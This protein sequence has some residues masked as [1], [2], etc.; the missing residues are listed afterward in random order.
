MRYLPKWGDTC[1]LPTTDSTKEINQNCFQYEKGVCVHACMCLMGQVDI[2]IFFFFTFNY[3]F[4]CPIVWICNTIITYTSIVF[5]SLKSCFI[6]I[7]SPLK[8]YTAKAIILS[9][10]PS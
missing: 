9:L 5:Y 7:V 10:A 3:A 2:Y 4:N 8:Y 1:H 6:L